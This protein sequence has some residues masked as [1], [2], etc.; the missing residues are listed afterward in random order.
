MA[1]IGRNEPCLCGSGM[2]F[3]K[4]CLVKQKQASEPLPADSPAPAPARLETE[5][6]AIRQAALQREEK[7]RQVGVFVLFSTA[8]GDAWLLEASERDALHLVASGKEIEVSIE[9]D[10]KLIEVNWSHTFS[11]DAKRFEVTA[12]QDGKKDMYEKYPV[13]RIHAALK[14]IQKRLRGKSPHVRQPAAG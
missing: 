2:K 12:Y 6:A 11:V 8:E 3:K 4:C 7:V 9:E 1:K 5:V 14:G 10:S 13:L